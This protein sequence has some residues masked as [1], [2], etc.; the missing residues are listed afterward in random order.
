MDTTKTDGP[1][2]SPKTETDPTGRTKTCSVCQ[3]A[4][5]F[6]AFHRRGHF[7]RSGLRA[8]CKACTSAATKVARSKVPAKD[9]EDPQKKRVRE[10]T[11]AARRRGEVVAKPCKVCGAP[12]S[13]AHH[14]RYDGPDAHLAIE[15]LCEQ[16]HALAHGKRPW[17]KQL[18]LFKSL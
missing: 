5:P 16:H 2:R 13:E 15:W 11:R 4:L 1:V 8:A 12:G 3:K 10:A 9:R 7:V 6:D 18:P 14:T 17:T